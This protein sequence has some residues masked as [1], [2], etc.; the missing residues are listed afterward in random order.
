VIELDGGGHFEDKQSKYDELRSALLKEYGL[1]IL[2]FN[3]IDVDRN[4]QGVCIT[5]DIAVKN[6]LPQPP[7]AAAPSSEGAE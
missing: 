2:R 1:Q 4:F 5:I 6:S 3:N 7:A